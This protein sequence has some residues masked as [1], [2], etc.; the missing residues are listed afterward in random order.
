MI[1]EIFTYFYTAFFMIFRVFAVT[2]KN[3]LFFRAVKSQS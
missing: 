3:L 2:K 1:N